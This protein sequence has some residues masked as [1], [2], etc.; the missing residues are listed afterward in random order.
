MQGTQAGSIP[1]W[2]TKIPH[3]AEQINLRAT[4]RDSVPCNKRSRV[5]QLRPDPAKKPKNAELVLVPRCCTEQAGFWPLE[6]T[7]HEF[8]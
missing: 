1:G 3:A 4:T 7:V 8:S 2:A 6:Q 5:L